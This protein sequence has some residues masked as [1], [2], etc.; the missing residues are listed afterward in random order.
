MLKR[1]SIQD[2]WGAPIP[3]V[4][5]KNLLANKRRR[6]LGV[7]ARSDVAPSGILDAQIFIR[8]H[9]S[10]TKRDVLHDHLPPGDF[11]R[12]TTVSARAHRPAK[13][14]SRRLQDC[15]QRGVDRCWFREGWLIFG[16]GKF[17]QLPGN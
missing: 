16:A 4:A 2:V 3:A 14:R 12:W 10:F 8:S 6:T 7:P 9:R 5:G 1:G 13:R 15:H 11:A 17:S